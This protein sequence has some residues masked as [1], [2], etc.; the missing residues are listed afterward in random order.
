VGVTELIA[1]GFGSFDALHVAF[2]EA[3][4]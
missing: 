1:R 3:A 2:A 4:A